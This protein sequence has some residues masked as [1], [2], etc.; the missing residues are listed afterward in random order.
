MSSKVTF[1]SRWLHCAQNMKGYPPVSRHIKKHQV[2]MWVKQL[3]FSLLAGEPLHNLWDI[4]LQ[5]LSTVRHSPNWSETTKQW[6][7]NSPLITPVSLSGTNV[8]Q[9][10]VSNTHKHQNQTSL[11]P[12]SIN[13]YRLWSLYFD[14]EAIVPFL[15][16][17]IF[18]EA[19]R[20]VV[21]TTLL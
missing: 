2:T 17:I 5:I 10:S 16:Y 13:T 12:T 7:K 15:V 14:V 20:A 8:S 3:I 11:R 9:S 19:N 1:E 21:K 4:M 18:W 6:E